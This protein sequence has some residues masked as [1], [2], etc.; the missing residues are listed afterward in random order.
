MEPLVYTVCY[1]Y[2]LKFFVCYVLKYKTIFYQFL[3]GMAVI[4]GIGD[5][6]VVFFAIMLLIIML[7]ATWRSTAVTVVRQEIL[8]STNNGD[9]NENT[10]V[11]A[12]QNE[13][14]SPTAPSN[15]P[16]RTDESIV[17]DELTVE[18]PLV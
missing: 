13:N 12:V 3:G 15:Q 17:S 14:N 8:T 2:M 6:V 5:E 18:D 9:V 1:T 10:A 16:S 4:E 7:M 11:D